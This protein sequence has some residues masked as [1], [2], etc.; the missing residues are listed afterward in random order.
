MSAA[1]AEGRAAAAAGKSKSDN[2]YY[3][4]DLMDM[5]GNVAVGY[6]IGDPLKSKPKDEEALQKFHE[7]NEGYSDKKREMES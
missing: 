1:Y 3:T 2:P 6:W 4:E 7:W 5:F